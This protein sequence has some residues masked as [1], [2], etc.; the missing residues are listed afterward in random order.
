MLA[1][2]QHFMTG[3]LSLAQSIHGAPASVQRNELEE[4]CEFYLEDNERL[5]QKV[6]QPHVAAEHEAWQRRRQSKMAQ[7]EALNGELERMVS[8]LEEERRRSRESLK[9]CARYHGKCAFFI[10]A[11]SVQHCLL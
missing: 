6:N 9:L 11:C 5:R 7:L 8:D 10:L 1:A 2:S 4:R 3:L